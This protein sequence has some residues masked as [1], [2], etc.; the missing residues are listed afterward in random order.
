MG[1]HYK[2][3]FRSQDRLSG[4]DYAEPV[5]SNL[6]FPNLTRLQEYQFV[7]VFLCE[8]VINADISGGEISH[9]QVEVVGKN[10]VNV[11]RSS[12]TGTKSV[13]NLRLVPFDRKESGQANLYTLL[14]S[15]ERDYLVFPLAELQDTNI[16]FR[17]STGDDELILE[18][19]QG[20]FEGYNFALTLEPIK[21]LLD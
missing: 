16:Q 15:D 17:I 7:K 4:S 6:N 2:V 1:F 21:S 11:V 12:G 13:N 10:P 8:A 18:P 20:D 14:M 9:L 5:Y 3:E 19:S